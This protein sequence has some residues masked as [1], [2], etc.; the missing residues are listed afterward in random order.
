MKIGHRL[1]AAFF[2]ILA[3]LVGIS[4]VSIYNVRQ[5][6]RML[7]TINDVNSIKQRYA[8][9]FRGSVH[10]RAIALRDVTL[11]SDPADVRAALAEIETLTAK[12]AQSAKPLDEIMADASRA[13]ARE[14]VI[15]ASIKETETRTLPVIERVIAIAGSG[16][17]E[18]ARSVL[19]ADARPLF[20]E[21]LDRINQFIDLQEEMNK[22][23]TADAR[24]LSSG[25]EQFAVAMGI[26]AILCG[27]VIAWWSM[28]AIRPLNNLT[29]IIGRVA[30]G[31]LSVDVAHTGRR[32]E[33][34]SMAKAVE[35]LREKSLAS[36]E[37]AKRTA[38]M[39]RKVSEEQELVVNGLATA[40]RSLADRNLGY[41]IADEFPGEYAKLKKDFN[42]ALQSLQDVMVTIAD[43]AQAVRSGSNAISHAADDLSYRTEQQAAALQQTATAVSEITDAIRE[44]A[45]GAGQ[46]NQSVAGATEDAAGGRQ[47]A[48]EAIGAMDDIQKSAQ[49]IAQITNVI[50][51]IAFQTNLLALNAGVEAARAG[52]AGRGFAV[53]ASEVRALAQRSS[54]AASHIKKL[55]ESSSTQ[56]AKGVDLVTETGHALDRIVAKVENIAGLVNQISV[57]T[58][59]QAR[60][61]HSINQAVG[62]MDKMTHQNTA[63]V[64]Q[65]TEAS[66]SL[67]SEANEM[68][69]LLTQFN[70]GRRADKSSSVA[71]FAASARAPSW[72]R[73]D[74]D[75]DD[76]ALAS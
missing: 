51:G 46:V 44:T 18:Q 26:C 5:I 4:V 42:D 17:V 58:E 69:G 68:A 16:N 41:R 29:R 6:D 8:I 22:A 20:V 38:E 32:D 28:G 27:L 74:S 40:L 47:L 33:V 36:R 71:A 25:F 49:E 43:N 1:S 9:N 12:Y 55:I 61:M 11:L 66:R 30:E 65:S 7:T 70:L 64:E 39:Q 67:A 13:G 56:V 45:Q 35:V 50:D 52:D 63:M 57:S 54:D 76:F 37:L 53:V 2:L 34:G 24:A 14:R 23:I 62:D 73:G 15:L 72:P 10:D 19:V 60:N 3:M 59:D 48:R 21:W 75:R 31:D